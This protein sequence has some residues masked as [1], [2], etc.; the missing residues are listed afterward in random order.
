MVDDLWA[1]FGS[2]LGKFDD[3]VRVDWWG[4]GMSRFCFLRGLTLHQRKKRKGRS[5]C[6]LAFTF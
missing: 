5:F 4:Y 3:V 1:L 2:H 6:A